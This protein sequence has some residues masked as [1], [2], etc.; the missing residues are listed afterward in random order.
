MSTWDDLRQLRVAGHKPTLP[1][2][3]TSHAHLPKRLE[4]VGCLTILHRAGEPMPVKLLEGLHV[5]WFFEQC[6]TAEFTWKLCRTKGINLASSRVWCGCAN[7]LSILPMWCHSY[8]ET[9][10]WGEGKLSCAV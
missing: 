5:I 3:V 2:I 10:E 6:H 4:G 9:C 7:L 8:A 1:V